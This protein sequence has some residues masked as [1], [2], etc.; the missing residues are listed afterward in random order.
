[1]SQQS[2]SVAVIWGPRVLGTMV[3]ILTSEMGPGGISYGDLGIPRLQTIGDPLWGPIASRFGYNFVSC[4]M[5]P[6]TSA[7]SSR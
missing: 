4:V 7:C 2:T 3:P 1:M 5:A 6:I